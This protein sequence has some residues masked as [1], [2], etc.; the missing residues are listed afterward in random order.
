VYVCGCHVLIF[1][2]CIYIYT[3]REREIYI[4]ICIYMYIHIHVH[5]YI[6]TFI[7]SHFLH[8]LNTSWAQSPFLFLIGHG[9]C[10]DNDASSGSGL[11]GWHNPTIAH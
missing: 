3:H 8:E 5:L 7:R 4:Y 10:C 6:K 11:V 9:E 2:I 1:I